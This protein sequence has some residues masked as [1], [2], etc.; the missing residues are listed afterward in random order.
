MLLKSDCKHFPGDRPCSFNKEFGTMCND[1]EHYS[2]IK[3]KILIIK[4]DA[5]GDVLRTTSLLHSI[6]EKYPDSYI[7]W[8]TKSNASQIFF[9]NL[10]VDEVLIFEDTKLIPYLSNIEF[11]LVLH[12]DASKISGSIA[13]FVKAKE[14]RGFVLDKKG[15]I[16]PLNSSAEEWLEMGAFDKYKKENKKTYQEIIHSIC[17][18]D[19]KKGEIIISLSEKEIE[20]SNKFE[21]KNNINFN[22][23]IIGLNIGAGNRWQYKQWRIEGYFEIIEKLSQNNNIKIILYGGPEEKERNEIIK[24]RYPFVIDSGTNN[25]LREFFS[26]VNLSNIFITGDTLGLHAA[27]ALKKEVISLFGP[28]SY[29]EIEDYGRITKIYSDLECLV[30]YKTKC[31]FVPNCMSEISSE[32]ILENI[33][34]LILKLDS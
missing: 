8:L 17:E 16:N 32:V 18:F 33:N 15:F 19:Y 27:T 4:L 21:E 20:F 23:I 7:T 25:N 5:V 10:F 14:K 2:P 3:F 6:K 26:L 29:N 13:S 24:S 28:T 11:D 34:N 22:D 30:C 31:D 12:P 9:N 1:C